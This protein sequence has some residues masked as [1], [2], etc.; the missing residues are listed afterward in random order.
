MNR[1]RATRLSKSKR[2]HLEQLLSDRNYT[3][4]LKLVIKRLFFDAEV[5]TR[6]MQILRRFSTS[7]P[8]LS[9]DR[10]LLA[11]LRLSHGD[12]PEMERTV[13][14]ANEDPEDI[15]DWAETPAKMRLIN[16]FRGMTAS[17]VQQVT[18]AD[19]QQYDTWIRAAI[20][21][22]AGPNKGVQAT[23]RKTRCA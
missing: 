23:S 22:K 8:D 13:T 7:T 19:R 6:A 3:R 15:V 12:L 14:G 20:T 1:T 16:G 17:Q 10:V 9:R 18:D 4:L 11:I 5:H 21:G 2:E